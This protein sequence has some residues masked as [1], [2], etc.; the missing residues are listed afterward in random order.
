ARRLAA[1]APHSTRARRRAGGAD[2]RMGGQARAGAGIDDRGGPSDRDAFHIPALARLSL[3]LIRA[4]RVAAPPPSLH[5]ALSSTFKWG[6]SDAQ[7][8]HVGSIGGGRSCAGAGPCRSVA[9]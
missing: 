7:F 4:A 8:G 1:A 2:R 5:L 3:D 9:G 6:R